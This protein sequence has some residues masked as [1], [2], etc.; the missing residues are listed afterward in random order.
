M[1]LLKCFAQPPEAVVEGSLEVVNFQYWTQARVQ[2]PVAIDTFEF[3]HW[4]IPDTPNGKEQQ[5]LRLRPQSRPL[6]PRLLEIVEASVLAAMGKND[7]FT[8]R[9]ITLAETET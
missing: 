1:A 2:N 6:D 9:A 7:E 4:P 5:H 3:G 8:I